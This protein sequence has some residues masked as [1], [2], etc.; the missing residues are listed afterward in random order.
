MCRFI[1]N[2]MASL[3]AMAVLICSLPAVACQPAPGFHTTSPK[4]SAAEELA[5]ASLVVAGEVID[6]A[7]DRDTNTSQISFRVAEHLK[8]AS[9]DVVR[10]HGALYVVCMGPARLLN[11]GEWWT[12]Y[13]VHDDRR[14]GYVITGRETYCAQGDTIVDTGNGTCRRVLSSATTSGRLNLATGSRVVLGPDRDVSK[15]ASAELAAGSKFQGVALPAHSVVVPSGDYVSLPKS[16]TLGPIRLSGNV[17]FGNLHDYHN[18]STLYFAEPDDRHEPPGKVRVY[19]AEV[20]TVYFPSFG[21]GPLR[22]ELAQPQH[23]QGYYITDY[24]EVDAHGKVESFR[25]AGKQTVDGVEVNKC[26]NVRLENGKAA[27]YVPFYNPCTAR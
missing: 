9:P 22:V 19:G 18:A 17:R 27:Q 2:S 11:P 26:D 10:M 3:L 23:M 13:A 12:L 8:G 6:R 5:N 16:L 20:S 14:G 7:D 4:V 25:A 21:P 15:L 1:L 24:V